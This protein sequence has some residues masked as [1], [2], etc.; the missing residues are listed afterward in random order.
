MDNRL[1]TMSY[2]GYL[3][4]GSVSYRYAY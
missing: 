1:W 2:I 3:E 4:I